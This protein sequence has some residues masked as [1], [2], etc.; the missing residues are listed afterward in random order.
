MKN[1]Y[2]Y[3]GK[4]VEKAAKVCAQTEPLREQHNIHGFQGAYEQFF[5]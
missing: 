1:S 4:I 3:K 2:L 5:K